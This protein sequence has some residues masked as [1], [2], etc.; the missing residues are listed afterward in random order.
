MSILYTR[1][2]DDG[3]TKTLS[4]ERVHKDNCLIEVNGAL[5]SVQCIIDKLH[6][7][8]NGNN[9]KH[10][11]HIQEKLHQLGGEISGQK[12]GHLIKQPISKQDVDKLEQW[13][14]NFDINVH[15][16]IRFSKP[17]AIDINETRVRVR[18]LERLLTHYLKERKLRMTAFKFI[19]RLSTYFFALAVYAEQNGDKNGCI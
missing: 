10:I 3:Y 2:G 19:N 13:I 7:I 8:I 6:L 9:I 18:H 17:L 14:D 12:I 15:E 16:F 5:D 11:K 4:G 1:Y